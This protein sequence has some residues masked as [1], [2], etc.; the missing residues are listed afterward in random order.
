MDNKEVELILK[1]LREKVAIHYAAH[2]LDNNKPEKEK[3]L[4]IKE[5]NAK[6]T[7]TKKTVRNSLKR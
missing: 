4:P 3:N 7:K 6:E 5:D 1:N 2:L